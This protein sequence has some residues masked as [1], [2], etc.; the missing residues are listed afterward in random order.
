M[1]R[2]PAQSLGWAGQR[3]CAVNTAFA[4]SIEQAQSY[5]ECARSLFR[6]GFLRECHEYMV[7]ALRLEL[8][9]WGNAESSAESLP[10]EPRAAHEQALV[11]LE[12]SGYRQIDRLRAALRVDEASSSGVADAPSADFDRIWAEVER[13]TRFSARHTLTPRA[14]KLQQW[15]RR[16]FGAALAALVLLVCYRLWGRP[17]AQASGIIAEPYPAKHAVDGLEA[18]EW[19]LPEASPGWIDVILPFTRTVHG[20]RLINAHNK[21]HLDRA[22]RAVRVTAFTKNGPA[23]SVDG[24]FAAF[25]EVRSLLDLPLEARNVT[26]IRVEILS[27]FRQGAGLAEIEVK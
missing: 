13:L 15:R 5:I 14:R 12:R 18:T 17:R 1:A 4:Q 6:D 23:A 21:Q 3:R 7:K 20:V 27:H 19:F 24:E 9:A 22:T 11:E 2:K 10:P 26:R 16:L 25:S 8:Q